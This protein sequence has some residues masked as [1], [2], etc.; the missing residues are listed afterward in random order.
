MVDQSPSDIVETLT[1]IW[2][3]VLSCKSVRPDSDFFDLGGNAFLAFKLFLEIEGELHRTLPAATICAAPTVAALASLIEAPFPPAPLLLLKPGTGSPPVFMCPG[4][5]GSVIDLVPLARR[6]QSN[7][8]IY[9]MEPPGR[10]G[11]ENL[12]DRIEG[13][14]E[15]FLPA[16]Q[17]LQP[18]GPYFLIG[19]SLG[20]LVTLEIAQ[21]LRMADEN[22]A[23]LA[24][25]DSYPDRRKLF[26]TQRA[27]L[28]LRLAWL[29]IANPMRKKPPN[30]LEGSNPA[31]AEQ[32]Y[33]I[34]MERLKEAQYRALRNYCPSRYEGK[35]NFIR[36]AIPTYFPSDP[37][38]VWR[39][40]VKEL[41]IET[42]PGD[43]L[44]MIRTH[45]DD[46]APVLTRWVRKA[47]AST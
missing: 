16:I 44:E 25:I 19:Y 6:L 5:G 32:K 28:G 38:P 42:V 13:M 9:G 11:N 7:Q 41:E 43:H 4:I 8:P 22:V 39:R 33:S 18:S 36:A 30:P 2:R 40:L 3:R 45:I 34:T 14:A 20:G 27:S 24:M 12:L 10:Y 21:R 23:L 17:H 47:M 37:A 15:F 46:L 31:L 1:S 35:V 29:R 26:F